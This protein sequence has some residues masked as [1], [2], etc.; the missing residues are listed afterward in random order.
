VQVDVELTETAPP[1]VLWHGTG[2]KYVASIDRQ[3]LLSKSRLYVHLSADIETARTVGSRHG[4]PGDLSGGLPENGRG[5]IQVLA[6]G[7]S[8]V[9]D[10]GS[11]GGVSGEDGTVTRRVVMLGLS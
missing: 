5:R 4:R 9:A 6:V 7:E 10:E 1:D 3:G 11:A 8:C 2:E